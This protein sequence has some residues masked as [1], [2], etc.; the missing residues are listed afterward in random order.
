MKF[1]HS[2]NEGNEINLYKN[3][4]VVRRRKDLG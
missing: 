4:E 1:T 3:T 2:K